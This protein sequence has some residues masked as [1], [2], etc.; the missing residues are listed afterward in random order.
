M[1]NIKSETVK[2]MKIENPIEINNQKKGGKKEGEEISAKIHCVKSVQIRS[3]F[4][5][6]FS[7][8]RTEYSRNTGK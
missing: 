7:C 4:W 1:H 3:Y 8:I 5:P 6:V 2:K